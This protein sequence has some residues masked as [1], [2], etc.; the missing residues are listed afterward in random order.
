MHGYF[1]P[2]ARRCIPC[3]SQLEEYILEMVALD[4][5]HQLRDPGYILG[6]ILGAF[7]SLRRG[8]ECRVVNDEVQIRK[9][10]GRFFYVARMA[11]LFVEQAQRKSFVNADVS[12]A[13]LSGFLPEGVRI[14][15]VIDPPC[16]L[17]NLGAW[18]ELP[19]IN[20]QLGDLA[21]HFIQL[22]WPE[23]GSH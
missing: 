8:M 5:V 9:I 21:V 6:I 18:I 16:A 11:V 14:L 1:G 7:F 23:V 15:L 3:R 10:P 4:D 2:R 19:G 22:R 20:L 13:Q 17:P 12:D